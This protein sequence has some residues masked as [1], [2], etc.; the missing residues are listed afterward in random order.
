M[1]VNQELD[2]LEDNIGK[3]NTVEISSITFENPSENNLIPRDGFFLGLDISENS[4]GVCLYENG[5]KVSAN[6]Y[7][8]TPANSDF[9]EV[10]LRRELKENLA[11]LIKGKSF[12]LII[13]EDAFQG[14]N[15]ST[16]RLLYALNTA[17]DEL[18]LDK[19]C[20]CEKFL[21]VS[22]KTWKSWLFTIDS[23]GMFKGLKD[24][25]K[26]EKCLELLGV[27][28]E[29]EGY[30]DRL[31]SCGMLLG[32]FLCKDRVIEKSTK[33]RVAFEDIDY[34][35]QEDIDLAVMDIRSEIGSV[36]LSFVDEPSWSKKKMLDYLTENPSQVFVTKDLVRLGFLA[37]KLGLPYFAEGAYFAFWVKPKKLKKYVKE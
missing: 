2:F 33:K 13:I 32:Y 7:L 1:F 12:N 36:S 4:T 22:N 21:R 23:E 17:I 35:Y 3:E 20:S 8:E 28:D 30:Q 31:D 29:G 18:I 5:E 9:R 19:V 27:H 24:K 10:R 26:I 6:I 25:I 14:I 15:P 34:E 16:T 11:T 37:D